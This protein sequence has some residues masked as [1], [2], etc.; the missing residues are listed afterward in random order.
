MLTTSESLLVH[1]IEQFL[2]PME[3]QA[4]CDAVDRQITA[5]GRAA[6]EGERA[7]SVHAVDGMS[8][9]DVMELYEPAGRLELFPLPVGATTVLDEAARRALPHLRSLFPSG[10]RLT[11]W[12]YLEYGVGQYITPHID[13]PFDETDPD[14][15]KVA[16]VSITLNDGFSGG[17]FVVETCGS[18]D[19]WE[20]P[21]DGLRRVREGDG[22]RRVREGADHTTQWYKALPRTRWRTRMAAG[23]LVMFGSQLSH[24]TEPVTHGRIKKVIGFFTN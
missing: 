20:E 6:F 17:D 23:G 13:M 22:L 19:L 10:R 7:V 9:R 14:H 3:C 15:V 12:I 24:S 11:S 4:I 8:T 16:G 1:S 21:T 2:T 5:D 18:P